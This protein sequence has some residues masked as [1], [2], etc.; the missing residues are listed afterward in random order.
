MPKRLLA[1][2]FSVP[3]LASGVAGVALHVCQSMGG[4]A[5]GDCDC[6]KQATHAHNG[7]H[8]AHAH[9]APG[10]KVESQAC[11]S[12][13]LTEASLVVAT[14][15][16]STLRVDKA[17]VAITSLCKAHAPISRL[18]SGSALLRERAPPT[19]HGP[20]L[21]IRHCAFLN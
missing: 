21:F 16:A 20:P 10:P 5:A 14:H 8:V 15:E 9:H 2:V 11:C 17:P 19:H 4:I 12:T 7:E 1:L 13:T 6:A 18:A 3:L